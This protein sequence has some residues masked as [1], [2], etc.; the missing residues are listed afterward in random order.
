MK[1]ETI[2]ANAPKV[3]TEDQRRDYFDT[4]YLVLENFVSEEWLTKLWNAT[5]GFIEESKGLERSTDKLDLEPNHS[6]EHPRLRRL[7]QPVTHDPVYWD[8]VRNGPIVDIT[9]D[10]LGPDIKFHHSKLN[11][12]WADGGEEVKWHQD[13]QFWPHT[14][15]SV[16]TIGV[17]LEDVDDQ[18]G[19]MG[20]I[21]H[22]H[23]GEIYNQYN[24]KEQ[25]VGCL[26]D[27]DLPRAD[28][29]KAV[30]LK[31]PAGSVTVHHC[32]MV[33]GS[34]PNLHPSR[35]RPLLLQAYSSADALPVTPYN[36]LSP[37]SGAMVR[38]KP[39][40]WVQFDET[41]CQIPPLRDGGY[42]SIFAVQQEEAA[43]AAES[44]AAE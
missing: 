42:R 4:G 11:F 17:Y 44:A 40:R 21:P 3:L 22:S 43:R 33:H 16:L 6:A 31:G 35:S 19:P 23:K 7:M 25:W 5:N 12:K 39:A 2:L 41:P 38:G 37:E 10:L 14:N 1:P 32:R 20:V 36:T 9:E 29:G 34:M 13:I 24:G 15:Y 18:M 30:Y 26:D 27:R 28:T 8:F